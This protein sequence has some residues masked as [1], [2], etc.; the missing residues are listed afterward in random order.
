MQVHMLEPMAKM[1]NIRLCALDEL[2]MGLGRAFDVGGRVIAVFRTRRGG[3]FAVDNRCPHKGGPLAEGM[4]AGD[5]VV[6]PLHAFRFELGTGD[7]DQPHAC[8]VKTYP[9]EQ[10]DGEIYI[11][12]PPNSDRK[13]VV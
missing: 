13:E 6:C 7:C 3:V 12:L 9:V 11:S 1:I 10:I 4:L 5:A 8:P 2:P